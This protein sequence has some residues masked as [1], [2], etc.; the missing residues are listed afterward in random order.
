ML[1]KMAYT[2]ILYYCLHCRYLRTY[3]C[4]YVV[5]F[6]FRLTMSFSTLRRHLRKKTQGGVIYSKSQS[7]V[8]SFQFYQY[9]LLAYCIY[10]IFYNPSM[11]AVHVRPSYLFL[12]NVF[13]YCVTIYLQLSSFHTFIKGPILLC[14]PYRLR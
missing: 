9:N 8:H 3:T 2:R 11:S 14:K 12:C 5:I 10:Y 6:N 7:C 1:I 13:V 4:G